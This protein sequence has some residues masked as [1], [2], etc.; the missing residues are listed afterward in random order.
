MKR[1][2][3]FFVYLISFIFMEFLF[4]FLLYEHIFRLSNI[5]MILFLIPF[6]LILS[7]LTN[8]SKSEKANRIIFMVILALFSIWFSAEYVIRDYFG[9]Y[10]SW[11]AFGVAD[12]V[13]EFASKGVIETLRRIPGIIALF[14]PF[15][16]TTIF[17]KRINFRGYKWQKSCLMLVLV[18]VTFGIYLLGLNIGKS[19]NFSPYTLYHDINDV[20]ANMETLWGY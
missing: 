13:A 2:N 19:A 10:I 15:I 9:C 3:L 8:L 14:V 6:S 4:K 7:I 16:I 18:L 1:I 5:N 11:G 20:N 17:H 12:Q